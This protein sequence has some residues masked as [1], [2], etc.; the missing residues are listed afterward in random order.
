MLADQKELAEHNML[1]DL[2]R[3]DLGRICKLGS[4]HVDEYLSI[5]RFSHVMHIGSKVSGPLRRNA[6]HL[7]RVPEVPGHLRG[8]RR[9]G[10][11]RQAAD[12]R[13][14]FPGEGRTR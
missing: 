5:H 11:L 9:H 6:A 10:R 2:G 12:A 4:V 1:V 13:Q 7:R 8:V 14:G 3:N